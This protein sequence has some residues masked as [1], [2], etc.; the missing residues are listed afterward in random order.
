MGHLN[1]YAAWEPR[2]AI[3]ADDQNPST[4]VQ[5]FHVDIQSIYRFWT[6]VIGRTTRDGRIELGTHELPVQGMFP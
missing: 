4:R 1:R 6:N 3:R 2:S 5:E